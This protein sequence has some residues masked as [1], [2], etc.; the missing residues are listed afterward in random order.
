[1]ALNTIPDA[2]SRSG[3]TH[4]RRLKWSSIH[5]LRWRMPLPKIVS[6][7]RLKSLLPL[8]VLVGVARG[9]EVETAIVVESMTTVL[10]RQAE[11]PARD[12]GIILRTPVKPGD[13]VT[14]GQ[15]LAQLDDDRQILAVKA[16]ELNLQIA[17]LNAEDALP[18]EVARAQ[19][20]EAELAKSRLEI[21]ASI[22]EQLAKSDVGIRLAE[23]TRETAQFELERA[24]KAREAFS[25]SVSNAEL[26]RLEVLFGQR[27][28]EIEKAEEDRAIAILK[29]EED[30]A[31]VAEQAETVLRSRLIVSQKERDRSV[32]EANL[33]VARNELAA[34]RL[35]LERRRLVAPFDATIVA[36]NRQPGEWVEPGAT[37][38]RIIQTDRLRVEGYLTAEQA[39]RLKNGMPTTILFP[40]S[41][42]RQG[43]PAEITFISPEIDPVNQQVQICAEFENADGM[44]RPG[45]VATMRIVLSQAE[46]NGSTI[47]V[48]V[49]PRRIAE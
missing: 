30:K 17:Q 35:Q 23:K 16:A 6:R 31:A 9:D 5:F 36:V 37:A 40:D 47:A 46:Q 24:R 48:P 26:N 34:A 25:A 32:A 14:E 7:I 33:N 45:L 44:V 15:I 18:L 39:T 2:C 41:S 29:P 27:T 11:I 4:F 10:I 43:I 3:I 38:L 42:L 20:R 49:P 12:S 13:H 19:V 8:L 21:V 1:M 28:L 22:A